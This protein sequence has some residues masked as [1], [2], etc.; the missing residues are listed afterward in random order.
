MLILHSIIVILLLTN[1]DLMKRNYMDLGPLE[2]FDQ[3]RRLRQSV[4]PLAALF[5]IMDYTSEELE[6]SIS[7]INSKDMGRLGIRFGVAKQFLDR[8]WDKLAREEQ[9]EIESSTRAKVFYTVKTAA[10][11]IGISEGSIRNAIKNGKLNYSNVAAQGERKQYRIS[12]KDVDEYIKH[13][14]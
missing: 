5:L 12:Q 10:K 1:T 2:A 3:M 8:Q 9:N 11:A 6:S 14:K 7:K 4:S 13:K